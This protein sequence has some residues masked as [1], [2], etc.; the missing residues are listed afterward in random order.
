MFVC[1]Q[2]MTKFFI[3]I[4]CLF[5][6]FFYFSICIFDFIYFPNRNL[7]T[8]MLAFV[9]IA[10]LIILLINFVFFFAFLLLLPFF[11]SLEQRTGLWTVF[12][13]APD[14]RYKICSWRR[15]TLLSPLSHSAPLSL[16]RSLSRSRFARTSY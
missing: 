7:S 15:H 3:C 11:G 4:I 5:V 8:F 9:Q 2:H 13:C 1:P 12:A 10:Y 16:T 14:T 6:F